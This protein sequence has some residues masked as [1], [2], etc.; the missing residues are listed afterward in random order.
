MNWYFT[1]K[2]AHVVLACILMAISG[3]SLLPLWRYE[4]IDSFKRMLWVI[5]LGIS[6]GFLGMLTLSVEPGHVSNYKIG[7]LIVGMFLLSLIWLVGIALAKIQGF[8][9][10]QQTRK[11]RTL[12]FIWLALLLCVFFSLLYV[13]ANISL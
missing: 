13:M 4:F 8:K 7:T 2:I 1:F 3:W 5:P 9:H 11:I 6:Q 12:F 10:E